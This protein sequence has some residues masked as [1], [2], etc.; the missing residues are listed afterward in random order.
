VRD[1]PSGALVIFGRTVQQGL[2]A[3]GL[4]VVLAACSDA[5]RTRPIAQGGVRLHRVEPAET[6]RPGVAVGDFV[7]D[8]GTL[9]VAIGGPGARAGAI[10]RL[11]L[12]SGPEASTHAP[13]ELPLQLDGH[14]LPLRNLRFE[15]LLL[16]GRP[17]LRTRA[18][19]QSAAGTRLSVR[20]EFSLDPV[21]GALSVRTRLEHVGGPALSGLE[22]GARIPWQGHAPFVPGRGLVFEPGTARAAWIGHAPGPLAFGWTQLGDEL[23]LRFR[24]ER[25]DAATTGGETDVAGPRRTLRAGAVLET[26][27][28]LVVARGD[29]GDVAAEMARARGERVVPTPFRIQVPGDA[30]EAFVTIARPDRSMVLTVSLRPGTT[31][32][33]PLPDGEFVAYAYAPG[34]TFGVPVRFHARDAEPVS[35]VLPPGGKIR[36]HARDAATERELPVRVVIRGVEG[37]LDPV[38]GPRHE[39]AGAST[40]LIAPTGQAEVTVPPGRYELVFSHGPEWSIARARVVVTPTLRGEASVQL[41]HVVPMDDWTA[42]DLHVHSL[43]SG[44]SRVSVP[45]RVASLVAEGIEFAAASEHNHVGDYAEGVAALPPALLSEGAPGLVWV[46]AVEVTTDAAEVPAGHFNVFPYAPDPSLPRGGPPP[47]L[48]SPQEIFRA[49]RARSPEAIIQVNHPRMEP[50]IGYFD[51]AELDPS[52]NASRSPLYDPG[53]DAVEVFSG[54]SMGAPAAIERVLQDWMALLA[55]GARYVGTASSD[56]HEIAY[57][58]AGYPRTYVYTPGAGDRSPEPEVVVR[59]LREGRA[60]GTSGPMLLLR[61]GE[62]MPGDTVR[63]EEESVELQ[64]RVMAAPWMDVQRV[65]LYRDGELVSTLPV[66]PSTEPLRLEQTV[67]LPVPGE[68]SFFVAVARG[69]QPMEAVLPFRSARPF[70]FTNP[71]WVER[72]S[73]SRPRVPERAPTTPRGR[74]SRSARDGGTARGR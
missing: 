31:R 28:R 61:I 60:F 67:S 14:E 54:Y 35:L 68:K 16:E 47:H 10:V 69:E 4:A 21:H 29:L 7:F 2:V 3:M 56:S 63:T 8:T 71:I 34:H 38:L 55:S 59:A 51:Q 24:V 64:V 11:A 44:D 66:P 41:S 15:T 70:A 53:Y 17:T 37:T 50:R 57:Y 12:R 43:P 30:A 25:H 73:P 52:R 13:V 48:V 74:G 1:L 33:L 32:R 6:R 36:L 39:A 65:E 42:C 18:S 26:Q 46:P 49:A 45:D 19:A 22:N 40:V 27:A 72:L 9:Q 20:R 58:G 23:A 5:R 62:Q